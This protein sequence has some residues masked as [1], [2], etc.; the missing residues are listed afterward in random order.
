[1]NRWSTLVERLSPQAGLAQLTT[2]QTQAVI[3]L[4]CL[5]TYA[6]NRI[7]ALEQLEFEEDLDENGMG[8][9]TSP[10]CALVSVLHLHP[11]ATQRPPKRAK[12]CFKKR[13]VSSETVENQNETIFRLMASI[14]H[15]DLIFHAKEREILSCIATGLGIANAKRR[16]YKRLL[17]RLKRASH[18]RCDLTDMVKQVGWLRESVRSPLKGPR[19]QRRLSSSLVAAQ[20]VMG[21]ITHE[22]FG[23][24]CAGLMRLP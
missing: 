10:G 15:S 17:A 2:T 22:A 7:S 8:D 6:D 23:W 14:A 13:L 1:M 19:V 18:Q 9:G 4:L 3:D 11:H 5:L 16:S 12:S 24:L 21:R 20:N